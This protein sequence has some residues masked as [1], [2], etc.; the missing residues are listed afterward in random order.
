MWDKKGQSRA[1]GHL[2]WGGQGQRIKG[3][4]GHFWNTLVDCLE[5]PC[6]GGADRNSVCGQ[7]G[8]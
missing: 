8:G 4:E 1:R 7:V 5:D 3:S 2:G 6:V